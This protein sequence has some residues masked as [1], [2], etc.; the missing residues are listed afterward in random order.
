MKLDIV[1][2][3]Y[4]PHPGWAHDVAAS[5]RDTIRILGSKVDIRFI[6]VNDGSKQG[7]FSEK[8]IAEIL[9]WT[10]HFKIV[11]S[12]P[13]QG[14]GFALRRG[15]E[16]ADGDFVIY[17][18]YD[19]PF[20]V[21]SIVHIYDALAKGADVVAALRDETYAN[22][23]KC[24]KRRNIT[25]FLR[26]INRV[27]LRL[28]DHDAQAGLKGFN[29]RGRAIFLRTTIKSFL[30]DTEFIAM[31][32]TCKVRVDDVHVT[33]AEGIVMSKKRLPVLIRE[34]YHLGKLILR[35]MC[36]FCFSLRG[37]KDEIQ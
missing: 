29:Q 22:A 12:F 35:S 18:D 6:L 21:E 5:V 2:P 23:L 7:P 1:L 33:I 30:F 36:H 11:N 27:F 28:K 20:G 3:A 32:E 24:D 8:D 26:W 34:T 31:A 15:V 19:F 37:I 10:P 9:E 16:E 14:K 13:N 17:T 25:Y 4:N